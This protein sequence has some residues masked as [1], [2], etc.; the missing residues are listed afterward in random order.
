[1]DLPAQARIQRASGDGGERSTLGAE[2]GVGGGGKLSGV[3]RGDGGQLGEEPMEVVTRIDLTAEAR[4]DEGVEGGGPVAGVGR[5]HE[6]TVLF[7]KGAGEDGILDRVVID[8]TPAALKVNLQ[9]V[10]LT[11]GIGDGGAQE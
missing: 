4:A 1:M 9:A 3:G 10:P 7:A 2:G 11:E 8:F 6:E 5:T